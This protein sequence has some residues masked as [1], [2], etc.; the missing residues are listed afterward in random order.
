[1]KEFAR[2][3]QEIGKKATSIT[4]QEEYDAPSSLRSTKLDS[5]RILINMKWR[6]GL[7]ACQISS[8]K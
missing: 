7:K 3:P 4:E 8:G 2:S 6:R 1:L 5:K